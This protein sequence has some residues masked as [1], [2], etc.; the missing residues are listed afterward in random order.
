MGSKRL[1][2]IFERLGEL[3]PTFVR[4]RKRVE[5]QNVNAVDLVTDP[6]LVAGVE[7]ADALDPVVVH[8]EANRQLPTGVDVRHPAAHSKVAGLFD[9][10]NAPVA[11]RY[12]ARSEFCGIDQRTRGQSKSRIGDRSRLGKVCEQG[13]RRNHHDVH[14]IAGYGVEQPDQGEARRQWGFDPLI[15]R[16]GVRRHDADPHTRT[17]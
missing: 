2:L 9:E 15:H 12:Q 8:L 16:S 1:E 11:R 14:R 6:S 13:A 5:G 17:E 3:P 4:H 10:V 7:V